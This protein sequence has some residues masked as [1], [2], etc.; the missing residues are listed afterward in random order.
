M[1]RTLSAQS[2]AW[3]QC[4]PAVIDQLL[5][6]AVRSCQNHRDDLLKVIVQDI[7]GSVSSVLASNFLVLSRAL[8]EYRLTFRHLKVGKQPPLKFGKLGGR[9]VVQFYPHTEIPYDPWLF[10]GAR[11]VVVMKKWISEREVRESVAERYF[12]SQFSRGVAISLAPFNGLEMGFED[13]FHLMLEK[14]LPTVLKANEKTPHAGEVFEKIMAP[15]I[16]AGVLRIAQGGPE[17]GEILL[18]QPGI[19]QVHLTGVFGRPGES[20][21]YSQKRSISPRSWA[22]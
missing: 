2:D 9:L 8:L 15:F 18:R 17:V 3:A 14:R 11:G 7:R 1:V 10:P 22:A 5:S 20:G 6:E 16:Q 4:L 19:A 21:R 12:S 13:A